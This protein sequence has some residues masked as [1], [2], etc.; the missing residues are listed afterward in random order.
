MAMANGNRSFQDIQYREENGTAWIIINRPEKLNSFTSRTLEEMTAAFLQ[1]DRDRKIGVAVLTGSGD[2]AFCT[3]GDVREMLDLTP[4]TGRIFLQKCLRLSTTIRA[5]SK[6][7]VAAV[8]GYCLGGGHELHLFCDLSIASE[9]AV[10]GQV[11]P[12]V[13]S[14]PIWGG[15]Q[16]LPRIVGEKRAREIIFLCRRYSARE[17][18]SFGLVNTVVPRAR[19]EN[20]V[21]SVCE[22]I[23]NMSPQSLRIARLSLNFEA[24]LLYPSFLH[25]IE[26][27]KS[28]YG[29]KELQEGM[30]AFLEKRKPDFSRFRNP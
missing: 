13:G 11:G 4:E 14:V 30:G 27:M 25:G 23:L 1:A 17:A 18:H 7:V 3:G 5:L 15:T 19:L 8:N 22:Q 20:E 2:R 24:D 9:D 21:Q 10:F 26:L 16:L 29:S 28:V 6:P 12:T